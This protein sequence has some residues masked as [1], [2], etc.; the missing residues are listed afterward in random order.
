M[1]VH[2]IW[3]L[4]PAAGI[5]SRMGAPLPKQYLSLAGSTVL[6][7]TLKK[8]LALPQLSGCV[9]VLAQDDP[10]FTKLTGA[11]PVTTVVGGAQR[12]DSVC[13]GLQHLLQYADERDWV[14]VH[15]AARPC[16]RLQNL[17]K[18]VDQVLQHGRGA[19]L[20]APVADTLKRV[21]GEQVL[22]T[23]DR[24]H[25]WLAH[26]P[27]MFRIGELL[28]ALNQAKASGQSVTDE[29]SAMEAMGM[30][31]MVVADSRDNI[32]ITQ[33]EDLALAEGILQQQGVSA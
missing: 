1:T 28:A 2:K 20:A 4:V 14:L 15:D 27:Q 7:I 9:V 23:V 22:G 13:C 16:V 32:K 19:L 21:A 17:Q 5:G 25:L 3:A 24:S 26:T 6:Q 30:Q 8:L 12:A 29:A 10:Y 11:L 33:P 18:L 31:P